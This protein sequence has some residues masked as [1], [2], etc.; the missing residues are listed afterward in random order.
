ME[1]PHP[2]KIQRHPRI[3]DIAVGDEV[4]S[5]RTNMFARVPRRVSRCGVR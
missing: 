3:Q 4:L 2:M 1:R 5:Y